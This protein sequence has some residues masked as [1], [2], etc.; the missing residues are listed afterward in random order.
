MSENVHRI[1]S[2][3]EKGNILALLSEERRIDGRDLEDYREIKIKTNIIEKADGSA[4]VCI[5]NTRVLTGVKAEI[6]EPYPDSPESGVVTLTAEFVPMANPLFEPG[7]PSEEAVEVA[8]VVDRGIRHAEV[9]DKEKLCIIPGKKVWIIFVDMYVLDDDG[10][11]FDTALISAI[12]AL[13]TTKIPKVK[14]ENEEVKILEE[15]MPLPIK[16]RAASITLAK[17][18][19]AMIVDPQK[20]EERVMEGRITIAISEEGK[21]CSI[22]KGAPGAFELE[23]IE[24]VMELALN[25]AKEI[26]NIL[27]KVV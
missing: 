16:N 11:I 22:Q 3:I 17:I 19:K 8:R 1:V 15:K 26:I 13:L 20:S 12:S 6:G 27:P 23:K 9:V 4:E 18:G 25:K 21:I 14:V 7:P 2:E 10:N 24:K 5:G